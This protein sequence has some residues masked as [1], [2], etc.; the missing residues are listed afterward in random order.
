MPKI[1]HMVAAKRILRYLKGTIDWGILFPS[2]WGPATTELIGYTYADWS[3]DTEDRK[4]TSG[5][6][7]MM[8]KAPIAWCS[9]KQ[10]VVALSSC[11]AEYIAAAFGASQAQW[12]QMLLHELKV[13]CESTMRLKVDNKSAIDLE[14]H[15]ISHGRSK[16]IE[17]KY[18]FL[19]DQV[20]KEKLAI[21]HYNRE[22]QLA[23]ILTKGLKA[24]KFE[25]MRSKIGILSLASLN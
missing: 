9:K 14:K 15:P 2:T 5:Y 7:L 8:G 17:I 19:R 20:A 6:I 16:H 4:S 25:D 1:T 11:E 3:G 12:L 13:K 10:N 22:D 18:H 23:D 24:R 21:E